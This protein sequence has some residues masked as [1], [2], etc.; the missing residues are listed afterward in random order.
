MGISRISRLF[1]MDMSQEEGRK[2]AGPAAEG[3]R[4]PSVNRTAEYETIGSGSGSCGQGLDTEPLYLGSNPANETSE[5]FPPSRSTPIMAQVSTAMPGPP[6]ATPEVS[7]RQ[8]QVAANPLYAGPSSVGDVGEIMGHPWRGSREGNGVAAMRR[9]QPRIDP[10]PPLPPLPERSFGIRMPG[11]S[12]QVRRSRVSWVEARAPPIA[13]G[14]Q[15]DLSLRVRDAAVQTDVSMDQDGHSWIRVTLLSNYAIRPTKRTECSR[16]I[17]LFSPHYCYLRSGSGIAITT[18]ISLELPRGVYGRIISQPEAQ[19]G[20]HAKVEGAEIEACS[21]ANVTIF[22]FNVGQLPCIIRRGD[23]LGAVL[24]LQ[25]F[26]PCL[27]IR[28]RDGAR[29]A[30]I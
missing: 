11:R 16:E 4:E 8:S 22:V 5:R 27:D 6:E 19:L 1:K 7:S 29:V 18:D 13:H 30:I 10:Y 24:V 15:G 12:E 9:Y 2:S 20:A 28:S 23:L 21:T 25:G 26:V 3:G 17:L 14:G